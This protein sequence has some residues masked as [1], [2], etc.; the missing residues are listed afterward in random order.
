MHLNQP[1]RTQHSTEIHTKELE[2]KVEA[3]KLEKLKVRLDARVRDQE[4]SLV[5]ARAS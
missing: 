1:V 5:L 2:R 4:K 3:S